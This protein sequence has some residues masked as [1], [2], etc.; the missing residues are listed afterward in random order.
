MQYPHY[1]YP[2]DALFTGSSLGNYYAFAR[3]DEQTNLRGL[4]SSIDNQSYVGE[5]DI[6]FIA[7]GRSLVRTDT[8]FHPESQ[9]TFFSSNG[10][11]IEKKF[12]IPYLSESQPRIDSIEQRSAIYLVRISNSSPKAVDVVVRHQLLFPANISDRFTKQPLKDQLE[13]RVSIL[14]RETHCE[15]TTVGKASEARVFGS[16]SRC[17]FREGNDEALVAEYRINV[18]AKEEIEI[19]FILAFSHNGIEDALEAYQRCKDAQKL[20]NVSIR[21]YTEILSHSFIFS[22]EPVINRGLQWA[23]I[24]T[25]RVQHRYRIGEGF[26]NDPPQDIVVLRDLA[27]YLLGSDYLTPQFSKNMLDLAGKS[28]VHENGKI[29]EYVHANEPVPELH[30]YKLNIN[31]DTPLYVYGL[32]H[33]ALTCG[34]EGAWQDIYPRMKSACEYILTQM[35]DGLVRCYS[36]GTYVWGIC[37]W[38]NIIDDYNLTGAVTEVNA[39]CY[40]ALRLAAEVAE[41]IG[42][43]DD[44]LK[45]T[46]VTEDLKCAINETLVSEKTGLYLLNLDNQGVRHHD[47]TGDLIFPVLFNLP[48]EETRRKILSRLS[49]QEMWTPYGSR[50]VSKQEKNYD[51]DFGYQLVGGIWHNLTAWLAYCLRDSQPQR[52]VEGMKNIYRLSEIERPKDFQNVVPGQFPERMHGETYQSRGMAM[53]PWMPPTYVWLGIEGLLGVKS[54]MNGLEISPCIPPDW[55]WVAIKNLLYKEKSITAFLFENVLHSS[56]Q[57]TSTYPVRC[58]T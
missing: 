52:L 5:W 4:W 11:S 35:S 1:R 14:K 55:G 33:Y 54:G 6:D 29:T 41:H 9:S 27:W 44:A 18:E 23:K 24:N 38:R 12:F 58:G 7:G 28:A 57:V 15:I 3:L 17:G 43:S 42:H 39:E 40:H 2:V 47:I 25:V 30:D 56:A 13:K 48:E 32:Y 34:D 19:P 51:P 8:L 20:L 31:D 16:K 22:P 53:S 50:T 10:V 45:F 46:R 37:G 36:D 26:T 49:D 21:N